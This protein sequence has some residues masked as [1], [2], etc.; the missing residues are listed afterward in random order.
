MWTDDEY[1]SDDFAEM[2]MGGRKRV[3][4]PKKK[5][6]HADI[7]HLCAS[8]NPWRSLLLAVHHERRAIDPSAS[9]KESMQVA[10]KLYRKGGKIT[11]TGK[12]KL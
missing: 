5:M 3:A 1:D 8:V 12:Y 11:K 6:S 9:F 4:A 10:S 7:A 2:H